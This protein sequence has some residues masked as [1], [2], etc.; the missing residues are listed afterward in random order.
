MAL[1]LKKHKETPTFL[2]RVSSFYSE[3]LVAQR[4]Y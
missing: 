2:Q 4:M 1:S 3:G